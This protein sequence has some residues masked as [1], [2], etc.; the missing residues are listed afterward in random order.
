MAMEAERLLLA[1][2][3]I[4]TAAA[5]AC[6]RDDDDDDDET[7]AALSVQSMMARLRPMIMRDEICDMQRENIRKKWIVSTRCCDPVPIN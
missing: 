6:C 5:A 2:A 7:E 1:D 4:V 3:G